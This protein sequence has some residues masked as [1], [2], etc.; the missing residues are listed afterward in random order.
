[1]KV[2]GWNGAKIR[3]SSAG[4]LRTDSPA[5]DPLVTL[6]ARSAETRAIDLDAFLAVYDPARYAG[7]V[8]DGAWRTAFQQFG[9]YRN[10]VA[11]AGINVTMR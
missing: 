8:G 9:I 2:D 4:P 5:V 10:I 11:P 3:A 6:S 7:G 1:M